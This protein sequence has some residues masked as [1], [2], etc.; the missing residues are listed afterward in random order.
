M[1]TH[2]E[3]KLGRRRA[4]RSHAALNRGRRLTGWG[5]AVLGMPVLAAALLPFR[6]VVSLPSEILLFLCLV[7]AVALAGGMWPAIT[8]AIG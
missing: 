7:V 4:A 5:M 8:A 3:A 6:D 2:E 1:I